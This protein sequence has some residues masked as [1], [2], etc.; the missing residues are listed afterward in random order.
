LPNDHYSFLVPNAR[1]I[2]EP[3]YANGMSERG[4]FGQGSTLDTTQI[5]VKGCAAFGGRR[6]NNFGPHSW[7]YFAAI[8]SKEGIIHEQVILKLNWCLRRHCEAPVHKRVKDMGVPYTPGLLYSATLDLR[9]TCDYKCEMPLIENGGEE[10][11]YYY[12]DISR[13]E[14]G[15]LK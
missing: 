5:V 14:G 13:P 10:V 15:V 8:S 9:S 2:I 7:L 4:Q 1:G 6:R 12:M 3:F 11:N